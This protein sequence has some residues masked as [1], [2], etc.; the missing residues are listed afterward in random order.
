M[1]KTVLFLNLNMSTMEQKVKSI[2]IFYKHIKY[3]LL[4][5]SSS[6][7]TLF[8][9]LKMNSMD[10]RLETLG[11]NMSQK[12]MNRI[13]IIKDPWSLKKTFSNWKLQRRSF[14]KDKPASTLRIIGQNMNLSVKVEIIH[15]GIKRIFVK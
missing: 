14:R 4:F 5:N 1:S 7:S 6:Q 13:F 9:Q 2:F 3:T 11:K 10:I 8:L 12:K 15:F